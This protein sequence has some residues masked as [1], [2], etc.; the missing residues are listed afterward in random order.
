VT[1]RWLLALA[2]V[3]TMAVPAWATSA[4]PTVVERRLGNGAALLV[5][6]QH[7]LPIVQV[8]VLIDAGG[9]HDPPQRGGLASLTAGL[10]TKGTEGRSAEEIS[11][12]ID[13]VGGALSAQ[14]GMDYAAVSL[15]VLRKDLGLGLDLLAEV[16]LRPVFAL[17]ELERRRESMLASIRSGEDNP[18]VVADKAFRATLFG[19]EPYGHPVIGTR[20]TVAALARA[21]VRRFYDSH[22]GP[23]GAAVVV[24]GDVG[25]DEIEA[26]L[27]DRLAEWTGR[28]DAPVLVYPT[29]APD[30]ARSRLID[31]PVAQAAIV[32]G[33]R[34]VPRSH[35]EYETLEVMNYILG[36][37]GFSSRLMDKI[38]TEAGLVYSVYSDFDALAATGSFEIAMQTKN[39]KAREAIALARAEVDRIR[40]GGVTA[41]ELSD[42]KRYLSG[43]YP[44]KLDSSGEIAAFVAD[45]WFYRLGFDYVQ[46]HLERIEK[47]S[48]E[49]VQ[50]VAREYLDPAKFLEVVVADL[51]AA[52]L[53]T[54]PQSVPSP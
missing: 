21:D 25:V 34:G 8:H 4:G 3:A 7:N 49:D 10:V 39:D 29:P 27:A 48:A 9:R 20:E 51:A 1:R 18:A 2:I 37:G 26:L 52:G 15:K 31:R 13:F 5:S 46:K 41:D 53:E 24:V 22:W 40:D 11:D 47:V 35:P 50:R 23:R 32:L 33:Q 14:A 17:D 16:L 12:T 42:A 28:G 19:V 30:A 38:R 36:G 43:S 45:V 54:P 44:L 6:E